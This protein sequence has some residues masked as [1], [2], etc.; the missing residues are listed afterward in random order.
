[1]IQIIRAHSDPVFSF[2]RKWEDRK[3]D[4]R[5]CFLNDIPRN[6]KLFRCCQRSIVVRSAAGSEQAIE[7]AKK[8]FVRIESIRDW[9]IHAAHIEIEPID[10]EKEPDGDDPRPISGDPWSDRQS[11]RV[12]GR[13]AVH[14]RDENPRG[15]I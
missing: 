10:P 14:R 5:V 9:R 7:A 1:L 3:L 15:P 2:R 6:D 4:Y 8:E 12:G 13:C 11:T